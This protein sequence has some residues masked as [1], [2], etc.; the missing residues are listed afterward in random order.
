MNWL[1]AVVITKREL[2]LKPD[3][4]EQLANTHV[5][6]ARVAHGKLQE[7][8][9]AERKAGK[10]KEEIEHFRRWKEYKYS[11]L[12]LSEVLEENAQMIE[13]AGPQ[14]IPSLVSVGANPEFK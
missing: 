11:S 13:G 14:E 2:R 9:I 1:K 5:I 8:T 7:A 10:D 12:D 3:D 4:W 6:P